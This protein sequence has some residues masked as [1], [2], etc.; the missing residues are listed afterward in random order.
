MPIDLQQRRILVPCSIGTAE[1]HPFAIDTGGVVSLIRN[2]FAE[3]LQLRRTGYADL[4]VGNSAG[5]YP[6]FEA[7]DVI[8]GGRFRQDRVIFVGVD[9]IHFGDDIVG[10]LSAGCLTA[11]DSEMDFGAK[12]WRV[13]PDGGPVHDGWI[14]H[15]NAIVNDGPRGGSSYL[16]ARAQLGAQQLLCMLDTGAMTWLRLSGRAARASGLLNGAQKWSPAGMSRRVVR[17][18]A[19]LAFGGLSVAQPFVL[20]EERPI[21]RL[22]DALIGLPVL[23]RLNLATDVS[24]RTLFTHPN[25]L[26]APAPDYNM[27]GLWIDRRGSEIVAGAVGRGS[28]ADQAGIRPGDVIEGAEF[29]AMIDRLNGKAGE[30]LELMVRS[31][32]SRRSVKLTLAD[33]L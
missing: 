2:D 9:H 11:L 28:P 29:Q 19:V 16:F 26:G 10:S 23:E 5:R 7:N 14:R 17:S 12:E 18:R 31:G 33:F 1:S 15:E 30:Q 32:A 3:R 27:S 8:F 4:T 21:N 6:T 24:Q 25:A 20:V 22:T 13:Y